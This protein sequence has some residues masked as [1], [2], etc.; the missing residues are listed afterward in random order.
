VHLDY[1]F[2]LVR[3]AESTLDSAYRQV[4]AAHADEADVAHLCPR[5]AA[6]CAEHADRLGRRDGV[7]SPL[8]F[9][10][11]HEGPLG[12]VVDLHELYLLATHAE[13]GW[14]AILQAAQ[15]ARDGELRDLAQR[16]QSQLASQ[17]KWLRTRVKE[18]APQAL[19]V[20]A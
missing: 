17:L 20:A 12:L 10:G 2:A 9:N 14:T 19:V 13:L 6:Q 4:G 8:A 3:H 1:Y 18:A 16:C 15:A 5:L 7:A 11:P